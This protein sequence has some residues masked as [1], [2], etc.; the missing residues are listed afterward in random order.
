[1]S[2]HMAWKTPQ[3]KTVR[4]GRDG[5]LWAIWEVVEGQPDLYLAGF[6]SSENR[7][8]YLSWQNWKVVE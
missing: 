6:I 3:P 7:D 2:R 4:L 1:M 5:P 8:L